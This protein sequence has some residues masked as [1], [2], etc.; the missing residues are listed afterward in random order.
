MTV[1]EM[2]AYINGVLTTDG[3]QQFLK[4]NG[5]TNTLMPMITIVPSC[6]PIYAAL[7]YGF[8]L[9]EVSSWILVDKVATEGVLRH[10]A[11]HTIQAKCRLGGELHGSEFE[12][13]LQIVSPSTWELDKF[14]QPNVMIEKARQV[15]HPEFSL[16]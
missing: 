14:W 8:V 3:V 12:K 1:N 13:A 5:V 2:K 4:H 11:A 6:G 15:L 7:S 9:I 10:E 16:V